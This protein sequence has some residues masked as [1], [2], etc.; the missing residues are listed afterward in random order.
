MQPRRRRAGRPRGLPASE[1]SA[2]HVEVEEDLAPLVAL[3]P[4]QDRLFH[5][6][7]VLETD[8]E[9][10]GDAQPGGDRQRQQGTVPQRRQELLLQQ[11]RGAAAGLVEL[12]PGSPAAFV[13]A[14]HQR[15]QLLLGERLRVLLFHVVVE[16]LGT[17]L[18]PRRGAAVILLER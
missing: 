17:Q 1:R 18:Q 13:G 5:V 16:V 9:R 15:R 4:D 12:L 2:E 10:L 3:A 11:L 7:E 6:I 14:L 8:A